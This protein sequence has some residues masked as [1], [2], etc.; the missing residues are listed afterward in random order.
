M[1]KNSEVFWRPENGIGLEN[2]NI[3][4][5]AN[6]ITVDST[7]IGSRNSENFRLHYRIVCNRQFHV[8]EVRMELLGNSE[9]RSLHL[10]SDG[11]GNWTDGNKFP[12]PQISGCFE[13]D[14]SATPFTNTIPILRLQLAPGSIKELQVA[15]IEV[16]SLMI[17]KVDQ[18]YTCINERRYKYEGLFRNFE[19]ELPLDE[20]Y[21]V[22]DY[23]ETFRRIANDA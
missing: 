22:I 19:A 18:R 11:S 13:V 17:T 14:I 4:E 8:N 12:L 6:G 15:Y 10:I 2:C 20:N 23:P 21:L 7:V 5:V 3:A 1:S 16:P 9:N